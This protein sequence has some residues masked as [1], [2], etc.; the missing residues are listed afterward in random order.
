MSDR[1]K[2]TRDSLHRINSFRCRKQPMYGQDMRLA[3]LTTFH[4]PK[5]NFMKFCRYSWLWTG[6]LFCQL[7]QVLPSKDLILC[8]TQA[9]KHMLVSYENRM[10]GLHG[11]LKRYVP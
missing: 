4:M 6:Y 3:V 10:A 2:V 7:Q 5:I 9:L 11:V 8:S 1:E